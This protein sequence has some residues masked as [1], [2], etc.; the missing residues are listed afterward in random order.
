M[1]PRPCHGC[2]LK[3][4]TGRLLQASIWTLYS[5]VVLALLLRGDSLQMLQHLQ[6]STVG[7]FQIGYSL[8]SS[9]LIQGGS[10]L[11]F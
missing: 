3:S 7:L 5:Y 2:K 8:G 6:K 10:C 1:Y 4:S 9:N 11:V